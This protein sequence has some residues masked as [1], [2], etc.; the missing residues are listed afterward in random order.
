[1][2]TDGEVLDVHRDCIGKFTGFVECNSVPNILLYGPSGS[3][4][5]RLVHRFL[6]MVY[7]NVNSGNVLYVD[8]VNSKGINFIRDELKYFAKTNTTSCKFKSVVLLAIDR[9]TIDAQSA[10]RRCI[11]LYNHKTRFFA[12]VDTKA[13]IINPLLSRFCE[14]RLD[15]PVID[16][17][18]VNLHYYTRTKC[19]DIESCNRY[20]NDLV[21]KYCADVL[22]LVA[23]GR[24]S[25]KGAFDGAER[26]YANGVAAVDLLDH[27]KRCGVSECGMD[28]YFLNQ[29]VVYFEKHRLAVKSDKMLLFQLTYFGLIRRSL[30]LDNIA[31]S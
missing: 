9:L 18:R 3:G 11:E 1:M 7:S 24:S 8:C 21:R 31:D 22:G 28:P 4:K 14:M 5:R 15:Y 20:V 13:T 25:L 12:V 26:L 16:G 10:L 6:S 27:M 29:L 17:V 23:E 19:R 30:F 2:S